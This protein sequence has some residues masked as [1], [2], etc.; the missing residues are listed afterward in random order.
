MV[1]VLPRERQHVCVLIGAAVAVLSLRRRK[2][3][4]YVCVEF[5]AFDEVFCYDAYAY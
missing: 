3:L 5:E 4:Q 1:Q 2:E